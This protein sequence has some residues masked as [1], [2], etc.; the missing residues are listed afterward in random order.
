[1][2]KILCIILSAVILLFF[3]ACQNNDNSSKSNAVD[4]EYYAGLGQLPE[5][6]YK[7][8]DSIETVKSELSA[9]NDQAAQNDEDYVYSVTDGE[10][11]VRIDNGSFV[12]YYEKGR[13]SDGISYIISLDTAYGF[14]SGTS[15]LEIKEAL[16][17]LE[18]TEEDANSDNV[19]FIYGVSNGTVLKYNFKNRVVMFVFADNML[20][21]TALYDT[22]SWTDK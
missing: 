19:F 20:C 4:L 10:K 5:C 13:E 17:E 12:Y 18:P 9:A 7:L 1:M 8:G 6:N 22:N 3:A 11:T 21:A 2:K 15:I 14:E 16:P